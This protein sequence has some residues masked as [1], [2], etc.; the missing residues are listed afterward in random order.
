MKIEEKVCQK[1][2]GVSPIIVLKKLIKIRLM[3]ISYSLIE[4]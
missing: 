2:A 3:T 1:T 4:I